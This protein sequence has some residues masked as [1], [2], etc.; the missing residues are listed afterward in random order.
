MN[1]FTYMKDREFKEGRNYLGASDAPTLA[2]INQYQTP[3]DLW[4]V[5]TGREKPFGGNRLTRA[6]N[7]KEANILGMNLH[8]HAGVSWD[9]VNDYIASRIFG[10]NKMGDYY[11]WTESIFPDNPRIMA[12][13]DLLDM[14]GEEPVLWQAKNTGEYA[15]ATR[16]K[17]ANKGYDRDDLS[18]NGI[19]LGVYFQEQIEM[20]CYGVPIANVAV[21]IGGYDYLTYAPVEYSKKTAEKLLA[22]YTRFL[23]HVD[24]D[25]E[26][27]PQTWPDIIKM[28]PDFKKNT[29]A[30]VSDE[31]EIECRQMLEEHGKISLKIKDLE[32]RKNDIKNALGLYI[33]G[34]NY[35]E[36]PD[37]H[38][39]ASA[40]EIKGRESVS[41]S[42]L[43]KYPD[44]YRTVDEKGLIRVSDSYRQL[45]I[46]GTPAGSIV[47]YTLLTTEDGKKWKR[48]RKKYSSSEKK[49]ATALLKSLKIENK[50]EK[51]G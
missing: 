38:S 11:S 5:F 2:G 34:N 33:G 6:G 27:T 41:V 8:L 26:P 9:I 25:T 4:R 32:S 48:S 45:Y 18:S 51:V 39:L 47:T 31:A 46:K 44:L 37:G 36:T 13:A 19:P 35:L 10:D 49:E 7:F 43:K 28:Y 20:M 30:V 23:W 24:N 21:E 3:A 12:H 42:D 40:S 17:D 29:K 50:W 22:L 15:A 1:N 16:K 14:T